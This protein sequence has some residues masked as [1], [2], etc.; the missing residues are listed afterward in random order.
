MHNWNYFN[1]DTTI[2]LKVISIMSK[3]KASFIMTLKKLC[4]MITYREK[5]INLY[6]IAFCKRIDIML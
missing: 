5:I 3:I 6:V 1:A 4:K 2:L